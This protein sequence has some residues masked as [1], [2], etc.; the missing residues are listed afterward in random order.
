MHIQ[1][2]NPQKA[3][4]AIFGIAAAVTG[5]ALITSMVGSIL[6]ATG[7]ASALS[8][9]LEKYG[10]WTATAGAGSLY[11]GFGVSGLVI[12]FRSI[13]GKKESNSADNVPQNQSTTNNNA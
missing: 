9:G 8:A 4:V 1:L 12:A 5:A 6:S 2:T 3:V 10:L 7:H 11:I 13:K